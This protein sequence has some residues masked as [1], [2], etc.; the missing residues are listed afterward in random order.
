M[1]RPDGR[2][3]Q[4]L[5]AADRFLL[6]V[7]R[8]QRRIGGV[9][10]ETQ[11][12]IGLDGRVDLPRLR[13]ALACL[14]RRHPAITSRLVEAQDQGGPY[15]RFRP[16]SDCP[17]EETDLADSNPQCV[18]DHAA[19]LLSAPSDP[20]EV[21]PAR[22]HLLRRPDGRDVL[23]V[24]FNHALVDH[25]GAMRLLGCL[26]R[27]D[28]GGRVEP[29]PPAPA[30]RD[31]IWEHLRRFPRKRRREATRV[32]EDWRR[33]LRGGAIHL[34]RTPPGGGPVTLRLISRRL[35]AGPVRALEARVRASGAPSL[36]MA[37]LA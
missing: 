6:A 13:D 18:L 29:A 31:P 23:L 2:L 4:P 37:V 20:A 8:A 24:Q 7:D 22:F 27:P 5:N 26:T 15:W 16:G 19:R 14:A 25:H 33:S 11:T 35:E 3:A 1:D 30:W 17:L 12:W 21:D 28:D 9:G 36:A 34:G 32:A 10:F